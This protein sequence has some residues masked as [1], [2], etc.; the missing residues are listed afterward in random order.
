MIDNAELHRF[1]LSENGL[2]VFADY[3]QH[4]SRYVLLHVEADPALRGTGA[5][6]RLMEQIV[7]PCAGKKASALCR[8][9][10]LPWTGSSTIR[11]PLTCSADMR[12]RAD[13]NARIRRRAALLHLML[14]RTGALRHEYRKSSNAWARANGP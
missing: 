12:S 1:E 3:R 2:T 5:G 11:K 6:G 10:L 7:A 8:A 9:A 14:G 13:L 4:D